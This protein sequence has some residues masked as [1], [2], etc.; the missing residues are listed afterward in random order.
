MISEPIV[1]PGVPW[2]HDCRRVPGMN[3]R[4]PSGPCRRVL[5][6][7]RRSNTK[8]IERND[9]TT[10]RKTATFTSKQKSSCFAR[11]TSD[12]PPNRIQSFS[13][14]SL[15]HQFADDLRNSLI[16]VAN[17]GLCIC[18][19]AAGCTS[20]GCVV[21]ALAT[22]ATIDW[23]GLPWWPPALPSGTMRLAKKRDEFAICHV[24]SWF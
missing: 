11:R 2:V 7:R 23:Q 14:V 3:T 13:T 18:N 8:V 4:V 22:E 5:E 15:N 21:Q 1:P 24:V 12:F 20:C 10:T 16:L 17:S 19:C 6:G 9:A